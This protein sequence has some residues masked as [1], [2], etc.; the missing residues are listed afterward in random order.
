MQ[1]KLLLRRSFLLGAAA[2]VLMCAIAYTLFT[3][4]DVLATECS[5]TYTSSAR[6]P[7]G[8]A[9]AYNIFSTNTKE[10]TVKIDCDTNK[11][12]VGS[13]LP[14]QY[15]Y[16]I[17][18]IFKDGTWQPVTLSSTNALVDSNWY[19]ASASY[20][21]SAKFTADEIRHKGI[22]ASAYMCSWVNNTWK[23]GCADSI[24]AT[25]LW[26]AQTTATT[27]A[28]STNIS[29]RGIWVWDTR[30]VANNP[31]R[32][33]Y[34]VSEAR[35][36]GATD[37]Y[38]FLNKNDYASTTLVTNLHTMLNLMAQNGIDAWGLEGWRAYFSDYPN[39]GPANLYAAA[40]ALVAFNTATPVGSARFVGFNADLE[41]HDGQASDPGEPAFP[42]H[43]HNDIK[44]SLLSATQRSERDALMQDWVTINNNLANTMHAAGLKMAITAESWVDCYGGDPC[45]EPVRV[46]HSVNGITTR[47]PVLE[48]LMSTL[49]QDDQYIVMSYNTNPGNA[50]GRVSAEAAYASSLPLSIRP[51]VMG[52]VETNPGV[53][54][55]GVSYGN[56][57]S[58]NTKAAV[59]A[60]MQR[61]NVILGS[62]TAYAGM[63]IHDW[64]GWS[65]LATSTPLL[66]PTA[67]MPAQPT[68]PPASS[69]TP[70]ITT[71]EV[72]VALGANVTASNTAGGSPS[73]LVDGNLNSLWV[74]GP[75]TQSVTLDLKSSQTI[76]K[77][78]LVVEQNPS[79]N[80][81]HNVYIS[82]TGTAGSW[83]LWKTFSG[84]TVAGQTLSFVPPFPIGNIRYIKVETTSS[85]SWVAWR[86]I[87]TYTPVLIPAPPT[88]PPPTQ[89]PPAPSTD[90]TAP[91]VPS[92]LSAVSSTATSGT[93]RWNSST[94][95]VGIS[96]YEI[97]Q[98][99]VKVSQTTSTTYTSNTLYGDRWYSFA[100]VALDAA[101]NRSAKS[102][103]KGLRTAPWPNGTFVNGTNI[104]TIPFVSTQVRK[105][106]LLNGALLTSQPSGRT[107]VI[108]GGQVVADGLT[109][110]N[111]DFATGSDGWVKQDYIVPT[112]LGY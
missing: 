91:S 84:N 14:T 28:T 53:G 20:D 64:Y 18:H 80:S 62:N 40:N 30:A 101:S 82:T 35:R 15:I 23:C 48:R 111:V 70:P 108:V 16:K 60:D 46:P 7:S 71:T 77:V 3:P 103:A 73:A 81:V 8:F 38:L 50:A 94:D 2:I 92:G 83:T 17:A 6:I 51:F 65:R 19:P 29:K 66:A 76:S 74:G 110:W 57:T 63:A 44:D 32:M 5:N 47:V 68:N 67:S 25:P 24:C 75:V 104:K 88:P 31:A 100:I 98:N 69:S 9:A 55:S 34:F 90:T 112:S 56:H 59:L 1:R 72:N 13:N 87:E 27:T 79:G 85:T 52:S 42:T 102:A 78:N 93:I 96:G 106:P 49:R 107:G 21:L 4:D 10:A 33:Q 89:L 37:A 11:L 36:A 41:P 12:V 61:F 97:W 54:D 86:E 105:T 58:K 26:Q 95:N 39:V 109:W 99:G 22:Y 45:T 43:F